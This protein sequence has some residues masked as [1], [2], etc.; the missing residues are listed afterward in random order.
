MIQ[1]ADVISNSA[2]DQSSGENDEVEVKNNMDKE[3]D[4]DAFF[5][6]LVTQLQNQDPLNPMENRDFISQMAQFTSLEQMKQMNDSMSSFVE[7]K[8]LAEG[9]SLI[10]KTVET[11][12]GEDENTIKGVVE[13]VSYSEDSMDLVLENGT[14]V[15]ADNISMI[16]SGDYNG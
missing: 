9:A 10:G 6:L 1:P 2:V 14:K 7:M 15:S 13:K 16:Y 4:Q 8:G 5:K 11:S 12:G 3:L